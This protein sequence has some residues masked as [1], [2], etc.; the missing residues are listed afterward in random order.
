MIEA[1]KYDIKIKRMYYFY[2]SELI[3]PPV[4]EWIK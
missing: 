1:N 3:E 4:K 2:P